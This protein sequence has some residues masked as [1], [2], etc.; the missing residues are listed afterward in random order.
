MTRMRP[1]VDGRRGPGSMPGALR[2]TIH[3]LHRDADHHRSRVGQALPPLLEGRRS[4]RFSMPH[5]LTLAKQYKSKARRSGT[6]AADGGPRHRGGWSCAHR[7]L[8]LDKRPQLLQCRRIP[9]LAPH[10]APVLPELPRD[11]LHLWAGGQPNGR[12]RT[13]QWRLR[14]P[15][16]QHH[17]DLEQ[18]AHV[19]GQVRQHV[20]G[21]VGIRRNR[22]APQPLGQR[23]T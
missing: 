14:P 10:L 20:P 12:I 5:W 13:V 17:E 16:R 3:A 23:A 21:A 1:R 22:R 11:S 7:R 6:V 9:V 18:P 4:A 15:A 19:P 2:T 8:L